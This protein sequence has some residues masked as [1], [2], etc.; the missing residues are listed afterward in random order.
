V[1]YGLAQDCW[2]VII[3]ARRLE[4]AQ[5]L[6]NEV[7]KSTPAKIS[8]IHL[9]RPSLA[10]LE[11]IG[12]VVNATPVGMFPAVNASPWPEGFPLPPRAAIYDLIYN[13]AETVLVR[14][15]RK[16]GLL[17][18]TG[19]WMLVEQ[20]ALGFECWTG[21]RPSK[22][23]MRQAAEKQLEPAKAPHSSQV[24]AGSV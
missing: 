22:A 9:D 24:N 14:S 10:G 19:L 11:G 16:A 4:Q 23:A 1:V 20:A 8:A 17:A 6:A 3:A 13:P 7:A 2:R 12:L 5:A 15:A 18:E 21:H